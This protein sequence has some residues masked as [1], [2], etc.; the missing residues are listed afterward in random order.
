MHD[1]VERSITQNYTGL[2]NLI[3]IPGTVGAAPVQNVGAYGTEIKDLVVQIE[4]IN[5][6]T[7]QYHTYTQS[8]CQ[9]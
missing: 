1:L 8:E 2:E 9:F 4:G 3:L 5:T 6:Q 7:G